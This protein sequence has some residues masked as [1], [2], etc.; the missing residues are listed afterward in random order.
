MVVAPHSTAMPK[1]LGQEVRL[2]AAGVHGAELHVGL[3]ALAVSAAAKPTISRVMARTSSGVFLIWYLHVD[4][5]GRDERMDARHRGALDGVPAHA[6]VLLDGARETGDARALDLASA[7]GARA[8]KSPFEAIGKPAS[9][10]STPRRAS[11]RAI[12]SFSA[13]FM[14]GAR[15]LFAVAQ[16]GVE[17]GHATL[18]SAALG[19]ARLTHGRSLPPQAQLA[20]DPREPGIFVKGWPNGRRCL[21]IPPQGEEQ[22]E[23][24]RAGADMDRALRCTLAC[25]LTT[26]SSRSVRAPAHAVQGCA[27]SRDSQVWRP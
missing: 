12:S 24:E 21:R 16:R 8:S 19:R 18:R 9:M 11:W 20:C 7:I 14:T 22:G 27:G 17:D 6:H 2:G 23:D 4:G 26:H 1:D 15:R 5:A 3:G 10:T 25:R 13:A